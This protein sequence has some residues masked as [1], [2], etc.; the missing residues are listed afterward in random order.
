MGQTPRGLATSVR[1]GMR[2]HLVGGEDV[3]LAPT[4][5]AGERVYMS[6]TLAHF[7][8]AHRAMWATHARQHQQLVAAGVAGAEEYQ[9][10]RPVRTWLHQLERD[11][12]R[13][14]SATTR[15]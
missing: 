9:R 2:I 5:G 4:G 6:A 15:L 8:A 10:L 13:W 3:R 1:E 12:N 7:W 11:C 14:E